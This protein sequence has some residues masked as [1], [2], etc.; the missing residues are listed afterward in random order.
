[1]A[2][3]WAV[4]RLHKYLYGTKFK[5]ITDHYS[6]KF[7][8]NPDNSISKCTSTMLARWAAKLAACDYEIVHQAGK[9][10]PQADYLS[11]FAA[12]EEA[13]L[14]TDTYSSSS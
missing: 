2:I 13:P 6:L 10:I 12:Q 4:E 9:K 1:M 11:R 3:V 8:F 7:I 14:F 5:I